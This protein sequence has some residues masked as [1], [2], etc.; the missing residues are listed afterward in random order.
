MS[1]GLFEPLTLGARRAQNRVL[2]GPHVT[3][4]GRDRA[5]SERHVAYYERRARGGCGLLVTEIA[6][7]HD[8][9]WPYERAPLAAACRPGWRDVVRACAPHG[10]LVLAGLGHAGMQGTTALTQDVLWAP[11]LVANVM[12]REQPIAIGAAEIAALVSGFASAARDA[13]DAG[14]DGVEVNAGQHSLLRQ[15]CSGLTNLRDDRY[16]EDRTALLREVLAAVRDAVGDAVVG[17]RFSADELAPWAGITPEEAARVLAAC[18]AAVD[19]ACIVRGSIYSE[20]ATQPDGHDPQGFNE[21]TTALMAAALREEGATAAICAQGSIVDVE[22]AARLVAEGTCALVEMTR[23]QIADPD[24]CRK[25]AAGDAARVRPCLLCNQ[26]CLVRDVRNPIVS[27]CVNPIAGHEL[28]EASLDDTAGARRARPRRRVGVVGGGVAG[29]EAARLLALGG[30]DVTVYE[31]TAALGGAVRGASALPGRDRLG[32]LV[33]WLV[34]ECELAGVSCELERAVGAA[35]LDGFDEVIIAAGSVPSRPSMRDGD[36]GTV[37][38]LDA[39]EVA[40]GAAA[41]GRVVVLDPVGGPVGIGVAELLGAAGCEV[42]LVTP[43]VVAGSQLSLSGDLVAANARL[44]SRGVAVHCHAVPVG[45]RGGHVLLEDRFTG[46]RR[47]V[48][49]DLVVD[50]GHRAPAPTAWPEHAVRIGDAVAP[51]G[52]LMAMLEARRAA[53]SPARGP[54]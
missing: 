37:R 4:L 32:A 44:A 52:L 30:D 18:A 16:G 24:L 23:A 38:P 42:S 28:D 20:A 46:E 8:S 51:R 34:A 15:F 49:A 5:L 9:D 6:S 21:A 45:I 50:A 3:N 1:P 36:D 19:Y 25:S 35:E 41:S 33:G 54:R 27:C 2:F 53:L 22:L 29:L 47:E 39:L 48:A 31:R 40:E 17:L 7:V 11:S 43:D 26:H 12:T 13:V 10:A 14:C